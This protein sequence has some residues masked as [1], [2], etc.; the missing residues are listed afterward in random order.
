MES[1]LPILTRKYHLTTAIYNESLHRKQTAF[2]SVSRLYMLTT[3]LIKLNKDHNQTIGPCRPT[4]INPELFPGG[5][6]YKN[7]LL[8]SSLP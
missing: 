1:N 3:R 6:L 8:R 7:M 4:Y 5:D 2:W